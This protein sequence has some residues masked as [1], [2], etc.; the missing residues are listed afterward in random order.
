LDTGIWLK[1][2]AET[3]YAS[4]GPYKVVDQEIFSTHRGW[5]NGLKFTLQGQHRW[6]L[7]RS[8]ETEPMVRIYAEGDDPQ[9]PEQLLV[10]GQELFRS[11]GVHFQGSDESK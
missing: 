8:S 7:L 5:V 3:G 10:L 4:I 6:L 11:A 1:S 2:L 9:E